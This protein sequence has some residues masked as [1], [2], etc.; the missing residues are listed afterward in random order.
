V[1]AQAHSLAST[2]APGGS[3][4]ETAPDGDDDGRDGDADNDKG[5]GEWDGSGGVREGD[6]DGGGAAA[7]GPAPKVRRTAGDPALARR[8]ADDVRDAGRALEAE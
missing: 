1:H 5:D 7:A 6:G 3:G 8:H 4:D 2:R